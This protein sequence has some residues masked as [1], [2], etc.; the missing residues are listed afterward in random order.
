VLAVASRWVSRPVDQTP[1]RLLARL[2]APP[3]RARWPISL[4]T[5]AID[6]S[7]TSTDAWITARDGGRMLVRTH[8]PTAARV[9]PV[10]LLVLVHGG[11]FALGHVRGYD[12]LA[13]HLAARIGAIVAMPNYR[14]APQHL[15]P[16]AVHDTMDATTW[17][18]SEAAA[19]RIDPSRI[20]LAGDSAGGNIAAVLAQ[21]LRDEGLAVR[22]QALLYPATDLRERPEIVALGEGPEHPILTVAMTAA[23]RAG[24]LGT[25]QDGA[26][27]L[28]SPIL[29]D[30]HGLPPALVQTADLDPLRDDG[31]AY[32]DALRAAGVPVVSTTY[33]NTPHGYA[34]FPGLTAH[35]WA[36]R[37]ELVREIARHLLP[38][39][40]ITDHASR[41]LGEGRR[42]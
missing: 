22:H 21:H 32:A 37:E 12:P 24:Y 6:R 40:P 23:F 15:A 34:S 25:D 29:G 14:K 2:Q 9:G 35:G 17:L 41:P 28:L 1:P 16:T 19:L 7:V 20:G 31:L 13:T 39:V 8:T 33:P 18:L 10:P 36:A 27:P 30:L 4:V 3:P 5:G 42:G 26:D 11:G 38:T